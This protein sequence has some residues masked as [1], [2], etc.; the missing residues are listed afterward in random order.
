MLDATMSNAGLCRKRF[1]GTAFE[2]GLLARCVSRAL[3][4]MR[5]SP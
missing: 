4:P 3:I 1:L 2:I 5:H